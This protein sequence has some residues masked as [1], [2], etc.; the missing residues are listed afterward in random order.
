M[1][2]TNN[3]FVV[4][5]L[6]FSFN[7]LSKGQTC[8]DGYLV[9][10]DIFVTYN[11]IEFFDQINNSEI[12]LQDYLNSGEQSC[13]EVI[14]DRANND[15]YFEMEGQKNGEYLEYMEKVTVKEVKGNWLHVFSPVYKKVGHIQNHKDR[16]WIHAK[17]M[18]LSKY[19]TLN[20]KSSL[21]KAI[22]L[23][24]INLEGNKLREKITEDVLKNNFYS[25]PIIE[26]E[27]SIIKQAKKFEFFFVIKEFQGS[28]LL[29]KSDKLSASQEELRSQVYGW[30]PKTK[31][32][33]WDHR[34]CLELNSSP[35]ACVDYKGYKI[36]SFAEEE[37]LINCIEE[38]NCDTNFFY[39]TE[40]IKNSRPSPYKMRSPILENKSGSIKKVASIARLEN[41][42]KKEV[43][44]ADVKEKIQNIKSKLDK[45]NIVFV[46]D[47]TSSMKPYFNSV[48][49]SIE[50]IIETDR[51]LN[52]NNKFRFGII[53]Y[54][55]Y[56]D[57]PN[58]LEIT[59]L[60][61]NYN[62]VIEKL[63]TTNTFSSDKDLPEAQFNALVN[64]IPKV[65]FDKSQS[66]VIVLVGDAG[67]HRPDKYT[68]DDVVE[69]I[70]DYECSLISFQVNNGTD[71][72]FKWFNFDSQL[73]ISK[74]A[75]KYCGQPE[76]VSLNNT[77]IKNTYK[78]IFSKENETLDDLFMFGRFTYQV[79]NERMD[80]QV[81]EQNIDESIYDY[82][83]RVNRIKELLESFFDTKEASENGVYYKLYI[84]YLRRK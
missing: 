42:K 37:Y 54:R 73:L 75:K 36:P 13:W 78:L 12:Y 17:N 81:F 71:D 15:L 52:S 61:S 9:T 79:K 23:T 84:N 41:D 46:I 66:N 53:I 76:L 5:V 22:I 33:E 29:S 31:I 3:I 43:D 10:P 25:S 72:S 83:I 30:L 51:L 26:T 11:K 38:G 24:S 65:G 18:I 14:S 40:T 74:S 67:N 4:L 63:K 68:I 82:S 44:L 70:V 55:D 59:P 57:D 20:T 69:K 56:P 19:S 49:N 64:G 47:G 45:V 77:Q 39:K 60:T 16:G 6:L 2:F 48:A 1:N 62:A 21:K 34:V 35:Q 28:V 8:K 80:L 32:T 58:H 7:L 27:N 50:E